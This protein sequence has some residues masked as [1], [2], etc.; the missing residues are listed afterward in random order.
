MAEKGKRQT[1]YPDQC[2]LCPFLGDSDVVVQH[3]LDTH[4]TADKIPFACV[5]CNFKTFTRGKARE[6]RE[7][8]HNAVENEN[9][10]EVF[11]GTRKNINISRLRSTKTVLRK[12]TYKMSWENP[13]GYKNARVYRYG[14][15][16]P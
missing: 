12:E 8:K 2:M 15:R 16:R 5:D 1:Y 14:G 13:Q 10:D 11:L 3:H 9:I 6:H 7:K 4:M